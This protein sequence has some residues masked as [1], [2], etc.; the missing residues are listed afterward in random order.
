MECGTTCLAIIFKHYGYYDLRNF[1]SNYAEVDEEGVDL[2]TLSEIAEEFGFE[3]DGYQLE[4][5][6][7]ATITLPSVAHYSGNHFVVIYKVKDEKVWISDPASG[8]STLSKEEFE[9]HWKGIVL[10]LRPSKEIFEYNETVELANKW[11]EN[12]KKVWKAF[13]LSSISLGSKNIRWILLATSALLGLNLFLPLFTQAIIDNVIP[14]GNLKLLIAISIAMG[15]VFCSQVIIS[16][17]RNI[18]L[19]QL[20]T[21]FEQSFF[22]KFFDHTIH[23]AQGYFDR[24]KKEDIINRFSEHIKIRDF[25]TPLILEEVMEILLI[26]LYLIIL[27]IFNSVLGW[28]VFISLILIVGYI[29]IVTP[30]LIQ[31]E[32]ASFDEKG[33]AIG[34]FLDI[35]SGIQTVKLLNVERIAFWKWK[36]A[37]TRSLNRV[38]DSEKAQ[39]DLN[40][41]TSAIVL[42]TQAIV[43]LYGAYLVYEGVMTLG[44]YVAFLTVY[45]MLLASIVDLQ[46]LWLLGSELMVSLRKINDILSEKVVPAKN[47]GKFLLNKP[48]SIHISNLNFAYSNHQESLALDNI[49]MHIPAGSFVGLVGRNGSGKTTLVKLISRLYESYEGKIEINGVDLLELNDASLKKRLAIVP[50]EVHIF[51]GSL[52]ENILYAMPEASNEELANAIRLAGLADFVKSHF[53]GVN[54]MIG[55]GGTSLSGGERL[56]VAFARLFLMNPGIIILDEASSALDPES[57]TQIMHNIRSAFSSATVISIAHRIRT[58][59]TA[60][61]IFTLDKGCIVEQGSHNELMGKKGIYYH[62]LSS[63]A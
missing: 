42:F 28:W 54:V 34:K 63:H 47:S 4:Y 31:L 52:R 22:G 11:R 56:K 59:K 43:Y 62:F 27:F 51:S 50:Q 40:V 1:L 44:T 3:S 48:T 29:S 41:V 46:Q 55:D 6:D 45:S 2:Y 30:R 35:L 17:Y 60:D 32:S 5:K 53:M 36:N 33:K 49:N 10:E 38:L 9:L 39:I 23:L 26:P 61:I 21:D 13:Y 8:L 7:L 16:Y 15:L 19:T 24:N 58:L 20:K 14:N 37:Y 25:F 12:R 18:L 57:E